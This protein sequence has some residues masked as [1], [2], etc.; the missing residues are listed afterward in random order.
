MAQPFPIR[1][2]LIVVAAITCL[3]NVAQ[4]GAQSLQLQV[5]RTELHAGLPFVL[6]LPKDSTSRPRQLSRTSISRTAG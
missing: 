5:D 6:S 2:V 1:K 4:A 3:I